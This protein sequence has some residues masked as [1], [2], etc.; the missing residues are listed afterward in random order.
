MNQVLMISLKA[1]KIKQINTPSQPMLNKHH[2]QRQ[3]ASGS[4]VSI[5]IIW[6]NYRNQ[7]KELPA[8]LFLIK[9]T[10]LNK[11]VTQ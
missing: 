1:F 11:K 6:M 8:H 2:I 10:S 5:V 4:Q 9:G 3:S 7:D